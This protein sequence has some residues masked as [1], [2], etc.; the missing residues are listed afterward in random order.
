MSTLVN[1]NPKPLTKEEFSSPAANRIS[2]INPTC[3]GVILAGARLSPKALPHFQ[4]LGFGVGV[5]EGPQLG[6]FWHG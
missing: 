6:P 2:A 3:T 1:P 5:G 4:G